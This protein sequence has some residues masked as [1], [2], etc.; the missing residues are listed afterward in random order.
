MN[1][2]I[3]ICACFFIIVLPAFS[4]AQ[5]QTPTVVNRNATP[6][7]NPAG[8]APT[9]IPTAAAE[10]TSPFQ[11]EIKAAQDEIVELGEQ[12]E[13]S[14]QTYDALLR[15]HVEDLM[16][17]EAEK[18]K[19]AGDTRKANEILKEIDEWEAARQSEWDQRVELLEKKSQVRQLQLDRLSLINQKFLEKYREQADQN[20]VLEYQEG[21]GF[22]DQM[23]DL[24]NQD[25]ELN[26][27]L[28]LALEKYDLKS[29]D[30][31]RKKQK[32]LQE[33]RNDLT[34]KANIKLKQIEEKQPDE[35]L[36]L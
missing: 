17:D 27:A 6:F 23:K 4:T 32:A 34:K 9:S 7:P 21:Q 5:T 31:I 36:S 15:K 16:R 8:A 24:E 25:L 14:T 18:A 12:L 3:F 26:K 2:N 19:R 35:E 1:K 11:D 10:N 33:T 28:L 30:E 13:D 29:A 20:K 22:I